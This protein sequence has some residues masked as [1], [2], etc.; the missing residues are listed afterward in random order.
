MKL[1]DEIHDFYKEKFGKVPSAAM[2]THLRR[3][4]THAIWRL[5]LDDDLMRAY[6]DGEPIKL[7][8]IIQ[9]LFPRFLFY[10]ADYPE[11]LAQALSNLFQAHFCFRTLISCIKFL[12]KCMCPRCLSAKSKISEVGSKRDMRNRVKLGRIDS[13]ARRFDIEIVR[14]MLFEKGINIT[15][16]K[17]DRVLGPT[18]T[19]PTRVNI[20]SFYFLSILIFY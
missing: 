18:S 13:D 2:L 20:V 12:A 11:K 3:E 15:S 16:V 7:F 1:G 10:S 19:V 9:A 5:I 4:L 8:D 6:T 17:I 14:R